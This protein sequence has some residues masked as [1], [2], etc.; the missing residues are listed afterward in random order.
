[1]VK[2]AFACDLAIAQKLTSNLPYLVGFLFKALR[3]VVR[4][5]RAKT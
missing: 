2:T 4:Q 3:H 5:N 1:M